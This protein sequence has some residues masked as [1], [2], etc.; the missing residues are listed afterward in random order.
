L[1][2]GRTTDLLAAIRAHTSTG[3]E[4]SAVITAFNA[5]TA[6]QQQDMLNFLRG[7]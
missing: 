5:L 6:Q 4:A 7:L 1:H 2:D 3:S